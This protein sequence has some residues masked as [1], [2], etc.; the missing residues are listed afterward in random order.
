MNID[1]FWFMYYWL[2]GII[3]K[4]GIAFE[5]SF[6]KLA[7]MLRNYLL[8]AYRN[9]V[10]H[11]LFTFINIFGL[12]LSMTVCMMVIDNTVKDL[13]FDRFHPHAERTW[14]VI[15][16]LRNP[17]GEGFKLAS[18]PLPLELALAQDS[19]VVAD[20]VRIYPAFRGKAAEGEKEMYV[21]GAFT[22]PAFFRVFGFTLSRGNAATALQ[23]PNSVVLAYET[24]RR[25]FG[26][27]NPIG[28]VLT[29]GAMGSYEVTG[30][31][32]PRVRR[33]HIDFD[34][35]ASAATIPGLE[36]SKVLQEKS[37]NWGSYADA[38]TY[39]LLQ[40]HVK[41]AVLEASLARLARSLYNDPSQGAI[42]FPVQALGRIS[43][44][45]DDTYNNIGRGTT[46]GKL[47]AGVG[48][49]LIILISACFN[50]TNL[51]I[52]RSL[53]RAKEVGIRKVSG[54]TRGQVFGQYIMEA[55]LIS[56]LALG[57][58]SLLLQLIRQANLFNW[59]AD[60]YP[61]VTT[62]WQTAGILLGFAL[63]TGLL[64][65]TLPAWLLSA[66]SPSQV[67]KSMPSY[68]LFGRMNLRKSLIVF[69]LSLSLLITV[70]LFTMYRQF[71]FM[72]ASD[73][74]FRPDNILT[75]E[76]Q[77][78]KAPLLRQELRALAGVEGIAAASAN[79]GYFPG[80]QLPLA[81]HRADKPQ[82]VNYYDADVALVPMLGLQ[83]AAGENFLPDQQGPQLLLNEAAVRAL[84]YRSA[85]EAVGR[86]LW[87]NDSV[88]AP[89]R[90]VLKDFHYENLGK[91][92]A[93][94][95]IRTADADYQLL[96]LKVNTGNRAHFVQQV[97][98]AWDKLAPGVPLKASWL[99][100]SLYEHNMHWG[101][102]SF[103]GYLAGMTIVI[104]AMG[105]LAL[106]IY[107]TAL[108]K[109]E[110]GVRKV[111]G[112]DVKGLVLLLSRGFLKLIVISGCIALPIGYLASRLFL[113]NFALRVGF[114]LGSI[115]LCFG[116]LLAIAMLTIV[117]Q[118]WRAANANPVE[119][120]KNE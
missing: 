40:P 67:L 55:V 23:Q 82:R 26:N 31:L 113:Q 43:P 25:F 17:Q 112:A 45:W 92:I 19:A 70:G 104:A 47:M 116:A 74:G 90:G 44:S 100:E 37:A 5:K 111:M 87:L 52:A 91:M 36:K 7:C 56:L 11:K 105:L 42:R 6:P 29:M 103:L 99:K 71:A 66:F 13:S 65:G 96:N 8:I 34:A 110:I 115:L 28:H 77:G 38:Y 95:A 21:Q 32:S 69:Q 59:E 3:I 60:S 73:P 78:R 98:A 76:L 57:L 114:G 101:D 89:V 9:I 58:A 86:L 107:T 118:T 12:A 83:L 102:I 46:W 15:T 30:V 84:G 97:S 80:G 64:A 14:R 20:V 81:A 120:L 94:L 61:P 106:V 53:T 72:A 1:L 63:F 4:A 51:S 79:F 75:V 109:K 10:K 41:P 39:A 33:S 85:G 54:A 49:G 27:A 119:S 117:S 108:R 24:A 35:Y 50:Y 88:Q 22:S 68:R 93:P 16:E 48:I 62:L 2:V 18:S